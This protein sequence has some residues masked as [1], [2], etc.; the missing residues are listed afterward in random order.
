VV[1]TWTAL[2]VVAVLGVLVFFLW[3]WVRPR[4]DRQQLTAE[5]QA[6]LHAN[7]RKVSAFDS[8]SE[9]AAL[10][11]V[12]QALVLRDPAMVERCFR[13]GSAAPE[14]VIAFLTGMND[15]DGEQT[16]CQWL[17]S[18]DANGMLMDGVLVSTSKDGVPRNRLALLT[19]DEAGVWKIDF[20]AFAR[21]VKP[22]WDNLLAPGARQGL[23]R[24]IIAKDS[25][26]N[27]P[28]KDETQ[29]VSY[30]MASPD[31]DAILIGYCRKDSPQD[32]AM[33]QIV[34]NIERKAGGGG[35]VLRKLNRATLELRRP[36]E[37]ENR[38]FEIIRVLAED[39][40]LGAKPFDEAFK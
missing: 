4:M 23:V 36:E 12:K 24:V 33:E 34:T 38:Q 16:G 19:P 31:N 18:M 10:E 9:Q 17:S 20:D 7:T 2:L 8:P 13:L 28:F 21:T 32:R 35:D 29:W 3:S 1:L 26:Y 14:S 25:Y 11:L 30:G 5:E 39:W 22:S 37:A 6:A 40:V 15:R 27:G